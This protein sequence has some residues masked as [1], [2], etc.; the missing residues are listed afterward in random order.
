MKTLSHISLSSF[1]IYSPYSFHFTIS[2]TLSYIHWKLSLTS[3][4]HHFTHTHHTHSTSQSLS[5]FILYTLKTLSHLSVFISHILTILI[6]LHNLSHSILYTLKTL[7]HIYMSSFHTYSSYSF[8]FTISLNLYTLKTISLSIVFS[9]TH[10]L[11]LH[12]SVP[13]SPSLYP[14]DNENYLII[15]HI[16]PL[17]LTIS[18]T[19]SYQY[20]PLSLPISPIL[21]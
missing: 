14:L 9:I 2:L 7:S 16:L 5:P 12:Y 8:H 1:H 4:C 6:P 19:L 15:S 13:L 10:S 3:L 21:S 20:L 17:S 11:H 18:H